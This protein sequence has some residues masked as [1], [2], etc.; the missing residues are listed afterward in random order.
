MKLKIKE[1][2][3]LVKIYFA[4]SKCQVGAGYVW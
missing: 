1:E 3:Q 4:A 2:M